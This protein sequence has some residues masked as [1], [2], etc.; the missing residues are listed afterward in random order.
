MWPKTDSEM[1]DTDTTFVF[2]DENT[3]WIPL[4]SYPI[5]NR[6]MNFGDGVFETMVFDEV[7]IRFLD[8]HRQRAKEGLLALGID[9]KYADPRSIENLIA[10]KYPGQKLRVRWN[11]FRSGT[12]KYTPLENHL[13]QTIHLEPFHA[14]PKVKSLAGFSDSVR[15]FYSPWSRF[16]TLNSLPYILAAQE[17]LRKNWD[18]ILLLD[19]SGNISEAGA[20]NIFWEKDGQIFT[21]SLFCGC[22][23]GVSRRVIIEEFWKKDIT[24]LEGAFDPMEI[25]NAER[26]WVSNVTGVSYLDKLNQTKFS[27]EPIEWLDKIFE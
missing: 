22:I 1:S 26:A 13:V 5:P 3:T 27:T 20:S 16:K 19:A 21:P 6:G 18:E 12:G 8:H 24:I 2:S 11:L 9:T 23:S 25:L 4:S 15:L 17:R 10:F 7:K 14:S